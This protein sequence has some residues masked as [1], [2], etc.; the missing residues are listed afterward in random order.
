MG[1]R[2]R[3]SAPPFRGA[4]QVWRPYWTRWRRACR[5]RES[6]QPRRRI[7]WAWLK[8]IRRTWRRWHWFR[9]WR[10]A[11]RRRTRR[12]VTFACCGRA[13]DATRNLTASASAASPPLRDRPARTASAGIRRGGLRAA[14]SWPREAAPAL[15]LVSRRARC[16]FSL[17]L[18]RALLP[19]RRDLLGVALLLHDL[20]SLRATGGPALQSVLDARLNRR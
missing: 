8:R 14:P 6:R 11:R 10:W 13:R 5:H 12:Q 15:R 19:L 2:V 1:S 3:T 16:T 18:G 4:R 17:R 9:R 20:T 7:R